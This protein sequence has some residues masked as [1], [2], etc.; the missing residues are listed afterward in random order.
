MAKARI[1]L[2]TLYEILQSHTTQLNVIATR[3]IS[4]EQ[5]QDEHALILRSLQERTEALSGLVDKLQVSFERLDQEYTMITAALRRLEQRFDRLEAERLS[6]R[7][8]A[9]ENRMSVL[10]SR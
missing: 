10:E 1:T 7:I 5:K 6:E 3:L 4:V 2:T 8:T 9:L